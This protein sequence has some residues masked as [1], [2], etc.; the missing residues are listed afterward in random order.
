MIYLASPYSHPDE[1]VRHVRYESVVEYAARAWKEGHIVFSPIAHSHPIALHGLA[2][3]W[4]QWSEFD[5]AIIGACAEL[6]VLML[7][8]WED[9][10]GVEAEVGIAER[11][12]LPV[13]WV[14]P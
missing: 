8:G 7:D 1:S 6:W 14:Q 3:T 4:E 2:G 10:E 13:R 9:S 11:L 12:G 5:S